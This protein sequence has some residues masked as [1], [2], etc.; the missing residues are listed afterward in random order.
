MFLVLPTF[1]KSIVMVKIIENVGS[2]ILRRVGVILVMN[3]LV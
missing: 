3:Q 1:T 2:R